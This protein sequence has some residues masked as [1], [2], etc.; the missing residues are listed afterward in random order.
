M[1]FSEVKKKKELNI[2][3]HCYPKDYSFD[4]E[5]MTAPNLYSWPVFLNG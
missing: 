2:D 5:I 3:L 1:A 4:N